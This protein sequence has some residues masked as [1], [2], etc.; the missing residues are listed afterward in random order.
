MKLF[1][2]RFRAA[3]LQLRGTLRYS[4]HDSAGEP[5]VRLTRQG[6]TGHQ[7]TTFICASAVLGHNL[8]VK[9]SN[10]LYTLLGG[11]A[12][13]SPTQWGSRYFCVCAR[14]RF[15]TR[16]QVS[17]KMWIWRAGGGPLR[18]STLPVCGRANR[19]GHD[20]PMLRPGRIIDVS[21]L[22]SARAGGKTST[23]SGH[24][25]EIYERMA[26]RLFFPVF[27]FLRVL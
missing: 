17:E 1:R 12:S 25:P 14:V 11:G 24:S 6:K 3:E 2:A 27:C 22:G 13:D 20:S 18:T 21:I 16:P 26:P 23:R 9:Y 10:I 7:A 5:S 19:Q 4:T 8:L 15:G